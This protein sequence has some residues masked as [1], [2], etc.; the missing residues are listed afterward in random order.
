MRSPS[1]YLLATL[2]FNTIIVNSTMTTEAEI[3]PAILQLAFTRLS[4]KTARDLPL[5]RPLTLYTMGGAMVTTI[6]G[7]RESTHDVDVSFVIAL[8]QYEGIYPHIVQTIKDCVDEV[9]DDL[10]EA[11]IDL[12]HGAWLN[13]AVDMCLIDGI[14]PISWIVSYKQI[15]PIKSTLKWTI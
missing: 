11:G 5:L 2:L 9:Y 4:L 15:L 14:P 13:N 12:G 6:L 7:T 10:F 1:R 3:N 8:E